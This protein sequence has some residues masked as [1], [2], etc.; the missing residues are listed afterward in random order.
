MAVEDREARKPYIMLC[1]HVWPVS[2]PRH[3]NAPT[4]STTC[5]VPPGRTVREGQS[6]TLTISLG[7][8]YVTVPDVTNYL[9]ADG[10]QQQD[11]ADL[12]QQFDRVGVLDEPQ[13]RGAAQDA[14]QQ[15]PHDGR[16]FDLVADEQ[17]ADGKAENGD[18]VRKKRDVHSSGG[19]IKA[20]RMNSTFF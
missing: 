13:G 4:V 5:A 10:E 7:I 1:C 18:D 17:D 2:T 12:R 20:E 9:Q 14:G 8:Q 3:K 19:S 15:E 16:D 11:H 6:V